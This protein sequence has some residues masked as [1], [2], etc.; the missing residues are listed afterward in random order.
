EHPQVSAPSP[1]SQAVSPSGTARAPA[2][3]VTHPRWPEWLTAD[4]IWEALGFLFVGLVAVGILVGI[5][6]ALMTPGPTPEQVEKARIKREAKEPLD[7]KTDDEMRAV[8]EAQIQ[9]EMERQ[10]KQR[11]N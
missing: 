10:R 3:L 7:Q 4:N 1:K 5:I 9:V 6:N 11:G 8:R 2:R